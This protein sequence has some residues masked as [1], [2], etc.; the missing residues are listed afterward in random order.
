VIYNMKCIVDRV[1]R[2][3]KMIAGLTVAVPEGSELN[4]QIG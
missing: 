1:E 2:S 3:I 4:F